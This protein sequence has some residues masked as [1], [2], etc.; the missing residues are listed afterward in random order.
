M[1]LIAMKTLGLRKTQQTS[2][3]PETNKNAEDDRWVFSLGPDIT[4][5]TKLGEL[6]VG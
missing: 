4:K 1:L 3:R 5:V 6:E 2:L